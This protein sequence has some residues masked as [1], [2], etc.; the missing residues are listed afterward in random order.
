MF[1]TAVIAAS[2]LTKEVYPFHESYAA[3][4]DKKIPQSR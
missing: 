1:Q 4:S 3:T 2:M